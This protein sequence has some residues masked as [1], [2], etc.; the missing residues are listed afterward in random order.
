MNKL[1]KVNNRDNVAVAT[2]DLKQ[3]EVIEEL[4][5]QIK[6]LSDIPMGHKVALAN[7]D[8]GENVFRYGNPIGR[9]VK[10]INQGDWVHTHNLTTNL[11]DIVE[12]DY[13]PN[14]RTDTAKIEN[15]PTFQGYLRSDGQTGIRNEIWLIPTVFCANGPTQKLAEMANQKFARSENFDGFYA[16][17]HPYGCSQQGEDLVYTQNILANLVNHPNAAGVLLLSLGCEKNCFDNFLPILGDYDPNRVKTLI[18]QDVEDEIAEGLKLI[19]EIWQYTSQQKRQE[20]P[21]SKLTIAV[22]CG[23][24]DAFSGITANAL[25]GRISDFITGCGGSIVMTEVPEMFGAEHLLMN[26]AENREVFQMIVDMI[27]DYKK[28]FQ[29]YGQPI[30]E[31]PVPGNLAGGITT[32]EEKSLGCIQKGGEAIVRDVL[33]YGGRV[34][35]DGFTLI[36]GPGNDLVGIT[37]QEAAGC[38]LTIFTTG[39]GTP[40]G[41][42]APLI[43]LAS[44]S[45]MANR[46][47]GWIDYNAGVLLEGKSFEAAAAELLDLIIRVASGAARTKSEANGY[48][49]IGM[50]RDGVTN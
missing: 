25:V 36:S 48:R 12:Y 31:N 41:F 42:A 9:A 49:Q 1:L 45:K 7:I 33:P 24:S 50:L 2:R 29:R 27:N 14:F 30:Y 11:S 38:V 5:E 44:N 10:D 19:D 20:L 28:Y 37:T 3:G 46:K 40:S 43:R 18:M 22:N 4:D 35:K 6:L 39:R 32:L 34:R 17:T 8:S 13:Q 47:Q 16:L 23:G 15:I 26:R 21:L